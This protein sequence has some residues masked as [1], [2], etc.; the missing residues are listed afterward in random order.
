MTTNT[1]SELI[2]YT[3]MIAD[4]ELADLSQKMAVESAKQAYNQLIQTSDIN[5]A[6]TNDIQHIDNIIDTAKAKLDYLSNLDIKK[7][8]EEETAAAN[9]TI[10]NSTGEEEEVAINRSVFNRSPILMELQAHRAIAGSIKTYS[11]IISKS[12]RERRL[13]AGQTYGSQSQQAGLLPRM[14]SIRKAMFSSNTINI[15]PSVTGITEMQN[16]T[17][18]IHN[19]VETTLTQTE[20]EEEKPEVIDVSPVRSTAA[21][22]PKRPK[23]DL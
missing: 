18:K 23:M 15:T 3:D 19:L 14:V 1:K 8:I 5:F 10:E 12:L 4:Q 16:I 22:A 2:Q 17:P 21:P 11:D 20:E 13:L 9:I 7:A 6:P